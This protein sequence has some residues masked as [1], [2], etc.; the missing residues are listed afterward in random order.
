MELRIFTLPFDPIMEG[1]PDE[2]VKDFCINK[3]VQKLESQ[4]FLQE[5]RAYWSVAVHYDVLEK[6]TEKNLDLDEY[7][8]LLYERLREWRK[9]TGQKEGIPV[10]LIATNQQ[11]VDMVRRK[12]LSIDA[13]KGI[14]GFGKGKI[15]KYG[16]QILGKVKAFYDEK[17]PTETA[18]KEDLPF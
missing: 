11:L 17:K 15:G 3:K 14:K 5:G 7:Q 12:V 13:M 9:E 4:F 2:L 8:K 10:F 6:G 1:F 16:K 18:A